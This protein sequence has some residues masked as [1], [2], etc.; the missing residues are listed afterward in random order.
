MRG[1]WLAVAAPVVL[2]LS[3][4]FS[5]VL[6]DWWLENLAVA[7]VFAVAMW[8][9]EWLALSNTSWM[10]VFA[11][12]CLHEYGALHAYSN[13][14]VGEWFGGGRNH[15]DRAIHFLYGLML[16]RPLMEIFRAR[17]VRYPYA[18]AVQAIVSTSAL[19]EIAEWLVAASVAPEL[20]AEFI[21]AQGNVW[22]AQKDMALASIGAL[23]HAAVFHNR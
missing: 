5:E 4:C 11:F 17:G 18:S 10:L 15:Y 16:T 13:V 6:E 22:D 1:R 12:F 14:P 20:G 2:A 3:G 23:V 19:Y 8:K 9:R 7:A 21:G